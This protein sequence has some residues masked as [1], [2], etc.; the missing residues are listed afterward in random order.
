MLMVGEWLAQNPHFAKEI[1]AGGHDLGNHTWSHPVLAADDARRTSVEIVRCRD[2]LTRLTGNGGLWFRPSGTPHATS[3][4]LKAAGAAGYPTSLS[5]DVDPL[6]YTDPGA[7]AVVS[8][9]LDQV[10]GGSIV[11]LHTL[12]PGTA[13]ALPRVLDGLR[14]RGLEPVAASQLLAATAGDGRA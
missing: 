10:R 8:R 14:A 6:D 11:S 13:Q 1:L 4:M 7:D 2:L 9:I 5:Y 12:Y 3:L